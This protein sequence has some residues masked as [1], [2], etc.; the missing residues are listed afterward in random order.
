MN[1]AR[2]WGKLL[3]WAHLLVCLIWLAV[4]RESDVMPD[5]YF[6]VIVW[7]ILA[8][9]FTWGFTVGLLVGPNRARRD[10]LWWSLLTIF[11]PLWPLGMW[12]RVML[13][14]SGPLIALIYALVFTVLLACETFCGVLLG[15]KSHSADNGQG[16]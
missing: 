13:E 1:A 15:V 3:L 7:S 16:D 11:L 6:H 9:Q 12:I 5:W 2:R 8:I 10:M 14:M 4:L